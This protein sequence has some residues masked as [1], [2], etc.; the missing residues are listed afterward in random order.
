MVGITRL[1]ESQKHLADHMQIIDLSKIGEG[2]KSFADLI[3]TSH[4]VLESFKK[5][6]EKII[7]ANKHRENY[8]VMWYFRPDKADKRMLQ[9]LFVIWPHKHTPPKLMAVTCLKINNKSGTIET[10]YCLPFDSPASEMLD[11]TGIK[12]H[13]AIQKSVQESQKYYKHLKLDKI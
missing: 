9:S 7:E 13:P 3:E 10:V 12:I 11:G 5:E 2:P 4:W 1:T 6:L 8:H